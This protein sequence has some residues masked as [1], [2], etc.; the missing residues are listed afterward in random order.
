GVSHT[1]VCQRDPHL[2]ADSSAETPPHWWLATGASGGMVT[3]WDI[4]EQLPKAHL[5]RSHYDVS[6]LAF[7]SDA[8]LL[9]TG[10]RGEVKIWDVANENALLELAGLDGVTALSFAPDGQGLLVCL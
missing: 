4:A 6:A 5:R 10:G 3:I 2:Y 7:N 1:M 8:T 9:A